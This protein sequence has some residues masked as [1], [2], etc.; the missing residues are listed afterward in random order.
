MRVP[1]GV[2]LVAAGLL[3]AGCGARQ[4]E[5]ERITV[6]IDNYDVGQDPELGRQRALEATLSA[7]IAELD[8]KMAKLEELGATLEKSLP[9][10]AAGE[11]YIPDPAKLNGTV[12]EGES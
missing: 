4:A 6:T 7:K 2:L 9:V 11:I 10:E 5:T 1:W 12:K 3:V 8:E